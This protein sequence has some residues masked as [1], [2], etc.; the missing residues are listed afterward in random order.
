MWPT[1]RR[2]PTSDPEIAASATANANTPPPSRFYADGMKATGVLLVILGTL[3]VVIRGF[4]VPIFGDGST[5]TPAANIVTALLLVGGLIVWSLQQI[6]E[7]LA[8]TRDLAR[9]SLAIEAAESDEVP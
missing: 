1:P 2:I 9:A 7:V 5:P 6:R 4:L 8:E 3:S